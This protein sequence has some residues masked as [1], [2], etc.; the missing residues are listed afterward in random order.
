MKNIIRA[1]FYKLYHSKTLWIC[2]T[3]AIIVALFIPFGIKAAISA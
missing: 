1:E 3:L 2:L